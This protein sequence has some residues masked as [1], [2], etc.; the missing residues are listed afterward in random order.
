MIE[1]AYRV[2][3]VSPDASDDEIKKAYRRLAKRYHPDANIGNEQAAAEKMAEVNAAYDEIMDV[4][5]GKTAGD[6]Y[7]GFGARSQSDSGSTEYMAARNFIANRRFVEAMNVLG[8]MEQ[9]DAEWYFLAGYAQ[10][11]L[12]NRAQALQYANT[13]VQMAPDHMEYRRL[14]S[15]LQAGG[16]RYGAANYGFSMPSVSNN[17]CCRMILLNL[18]LN[19]CC[20]C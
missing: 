10:M 17:W 9:K 13:A 1:N 2:L 15:M 16:Q 12:G 19:L 20:R 4:R 11:G 3:G 14:L 18:F 8:R 5:Q 6:P 7:S